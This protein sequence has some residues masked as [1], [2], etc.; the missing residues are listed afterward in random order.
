MKLNSPLIALILLSMV[1]NLLM[2]TG[3]LFMLQVYDRVL[4]SRSV[5]TLLALT[6]LI[7]VLYAFSALLDAL[8]TRIAV[9]VG[10]AIDANWSPRVFAAVLKGRL[11][12]S[13]KGP[14][15]VRDL[16]T[17]RQ[18]V[19]SGGPLALLDLPWLPIYLLLV[20]MLH[21][22]LGIVCAVGAVVIS[23][24]AVASEIFLREPGRASTVASVKRQQLD[25]D[26]RVNAESIRA[27]GMMNEIGALWRERNAELASTQQ[28]QADQSS[29]YSSATKAFRYFLQSAVLAVGAFL[30]IQ[31]EVTGGVMIGASMISSRALAPIEA[32]VGQWRPL[33]AARDALGR[34]Q[35]LLKSQ[36]DALPDVA[37]PLPS[38]KL[39][40]ARVASGPTR[41]VG[42]LVQGI[43]FELEKG[44]GLGILGL[45]GSGKSS[46]IR[47]ILG[48]WPIMHGEVRLDGA[49]VWQ[50]DPDRLGK[51]IGYLPQV[52]DLFSGTVAQN[53]ARFRTDA[54]SEAIIKAAQAARVHD[55][56]LSFQQGYDTPV[57]ELGSR[58]SAGQRQ[59]IGL[60][61][62]LYGDPFLIVLDE[63]NSNLDAI[64]D[65]A[66]TASMLAARA[67]G[68]IVIVVAHRPSAI[69]SVNKLL[70]LQ[71]GTQVKFGPKA[72][73]LKEITV[74]QQ[75][76]T[77]QA[78]QPGSSAQPTQEEQP[79][80]HG[81]PKRR[82]EA[83]V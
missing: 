16:D 39:T 71:N 20:F 6:G 23:G 74:Q 79:A 8:R 70:Y 81:S 45:S 76:P 9:R 29:S 72:E 69:A 50:Y 67:R 33:L 66:L 47:A 10:N 51:T 34:L 12:N 73:V 77:A 22:L 58:L 42:P 13:T 17:A 40:V 53:I 11:V 44:D 18:F 83:G 48:I 31:G 24:M 46:L 30:V 82:E 60:A 36:N 65:E 68:A 61:R 28:D 80:P 64:G 19:S 38:N 43:T 49:A 15:P 1:S 21:P 78:T 56:I 2:L 3:P 62:A 25:D 14:D 54:S 37:L 7:I 5:P 57:G 52:V 4:A 41:Q 59:R 63:P 35:A 75:R 55:L 32:L 27:M 26:A